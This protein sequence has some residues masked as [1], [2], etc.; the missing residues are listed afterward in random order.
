MKIVI[1]WNKEE[2]DTIINQL[3]EKD[4]A[5]VRETLSHTYLADAGEVILG[6]SN[7]E[8][9]ME[10]GSKLITWAIEKIAPMAKSAMAL[11]K[12]MA[13]KLPEFIRKDPI[14]YVDGI[15]KNDEP[16]QD[17]DSAATGYF[18]EDDEF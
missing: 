10:I 16:D 2:E 9:T 1:M 6:L 15:L 18:D 12:S 4:A 7:R 17:W 13:A 11:A 14:R 8:F 5:A 3:P